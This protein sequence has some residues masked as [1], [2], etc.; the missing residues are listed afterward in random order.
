MGYVAEEKK[1]DT[2]VEWGEQTISG[3]F[4]ALETVLAECAGKYCV[5]DEPSLADIYLV[6]MVFNANRWKVD[7]SNFPIISRIEKALGELPA[8]K[9]AHPDV[10]PDAQK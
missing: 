7:M 8:F 10:Q 4:A 9:A 3:G 5:G 1:A 6:P 2:K